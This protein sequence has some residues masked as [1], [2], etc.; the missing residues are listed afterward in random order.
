MASRFSSSMRARISAQVLFISPSWILGFTF[1]RWSRIR[2]T[3]WCSGKTPWAC[4]SL[5][6]KLRSRA[7]TVNCGSAI[8]VLEN[9]DFAWEV[10]KIDIEGGEADFFSNNDAWVDRFP[11]IVI[12]L[13]DWLLP[14]TGSSRNFL[15]AIAGRNFDVVFRGENLFCFNND[16]LSK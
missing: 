2:E 1:A 15:R 13:H 5:Q 9:G 11:L 14:G 8:L 16:L 7:K 3:S 4:R 10:C 12:E 6:S